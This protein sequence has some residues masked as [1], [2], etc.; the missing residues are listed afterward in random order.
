MKEVN[1]FM[2]SELTIRI[3]LSFQILYRVALQIHFK[4]QPLL[5]EIIPLVIQL[6]IN[7]RKATL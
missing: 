3:S 5:D 4:T 1:I 2:Q 6:N 7:V